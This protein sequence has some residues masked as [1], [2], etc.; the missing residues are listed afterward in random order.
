MQELWIIFDIFLP[1][2]KSITI[3]FFYW[4]PNKANLMELIVKDFSSLNLK[5]NEKYLH[6]DF[7]I[8]LFQS[9]NYILNVKR[10][11]VF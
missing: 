5:H 8:N 6:R 11:A 3:D 7:N 10:M 9:K 4:L 1:K 2:S